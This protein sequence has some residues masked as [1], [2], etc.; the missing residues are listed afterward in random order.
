VKRVLVTGATGCIGRH[1]CAHLAAQG[2]DVHGVS[3]QIQV[4]APA[5][6]LVHVPGRP[7]PLPQT[8]MQWH[9]ADLLQP[10]AAEA[11][12]QAV[13]ASHLL[14]LAWYIAPGKWAAARENYLW[15]EASLALVRAFH[16]AGGQ[17]VVVSGSGLEYD[18]KYG[19]CTERLTPLQPHTFYGVCKSA[20]SQLVE[21]Y[22]NTVGLSS[23]WARIFFL[24]GPWEH[25]DRLVASVARSLVSGKPART[26]HG[27]QIRD[28]LYADDIA[29]ALVTLLDS[30]LAGPINIASGE[31]VTL[32]HIV[33]RL[34]FLASRADLLE[35]GAIP[36]APTDAPLVVADV[37]RL[38][39]ELG[40]RPKTR[41]DDGLKQTLEW[42]RAR[43]GQLSGEIKELKA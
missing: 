2:W 3:S 14:H 13:Q 7:I 21:G 17:R 11:L 29:D 20:L 23:A 8:P 16:A 4:N 5:S 25:P 35:I 26:S 31:A 43:V 1:A 34:G 39:N 37:A 42:W 36:P 41:L 12:V 33:E 32:R 6:I 15:V 18:W 27:R 24:Y 30:S 9:V 28:Y 22:A 10:G 40:W 19:Y 38:T